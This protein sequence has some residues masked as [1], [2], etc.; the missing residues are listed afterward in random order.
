MKLVIKRTK[1]SGMTG[2]SKYEL[3][4][5]ADVTDEEATLIKENSLNKESV[6]YHDKTG[7]AE[8]FFAILMKM[9][10]DTNMTV[11]TF[12]RGTT[13]SCKDVL[14]LIEIEDN[15]RDSA[16]S[17]RAILEVAKKFGGEE[18]I[19]VDADFVGSTK[20]DKTPTR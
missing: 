14:E 11:D 13:F 2:K 9:F 10:R 12:V 17:L 4:V 18:V 3:Y 6:A 16:L 8:G 5:R 15:I 20:A 1:K 19:D 7:E